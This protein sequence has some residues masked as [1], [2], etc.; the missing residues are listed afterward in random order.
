MAG[1][2]TKRTS[3]L[4]V[5]TLASI[6]LLGWSCSDALIDFL[7]D[8]VFGP[9]YRRQV[10]RL[11]ASDEA[12]A[13][14]FGLSIAAHGDI[15]VI[16]APYADGKGAAYVFRRASDGTWTQEARVT[17]GD[18]ASGDE[19]S[20]ALAVSGDWLAIGAPRREVGG[21]EDVGAVY[22]YRRQAEGSWL[23][24][25]VLSIASLGF[26]NTGANKDQFGYSVA[27]DGTRLAIGARQ[28]DL[29]SG[30][31]SYGAV[32]VVRFD[33]SAWALEDRLDKDTTGT[34][35]QGLGF[36]VALRGDTIAAG[37]A[38]E[39]FVHDNGSTQ[40]QGAAYVFRFRTDQ[41]DRV[42]RIAST[43]PVDM[44]HLGGHVGLAEN[45][46]IVAAPSWE[47]V[48]G[49][50]STYYALSSPAWEVAQATVR[51]TEPTVND[52]FGWCSANDGKYLIIGAPRSNATASVAGGA[53]LYSFGANGD[54]AT[55]AELRPIAE[56]SVKGWGASVAMTSGAALIG[57]ADLYAQPVPGAVYVF[58]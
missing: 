33:G 25:Q 19:F 12:L 47:G 43:T 48:A 41:W 46:L 38:N 57:A 24:A 49:E 44:A 4:I 30:G 29:G 40:K 9:P 6:G 20:W 52:F 56:G 17:A 1:I 45:R 28:D 21:F 13:Y 15:A 37:A 39:G 54:L 14:G 3:L 58:E 2:S 16:G 31:S 5:A 23:Q 55:I 36:S 11:A 50:L 51:A 8:D 42:A 18:G 35:T 26:T 53:W 32:Y 27:L 10:Q 22:L 34:E 7:R